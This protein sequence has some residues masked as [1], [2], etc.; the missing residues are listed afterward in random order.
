MQAVAQEIGGPRVGVRLSPVTPSNDVCDPHP[1]PL[2]D[3]LARQLG[4]L[5]LA[6]L[7]VIEGTTGG[8]R[9]HMQGEAPFDY[10]AMRTQ[11][12]DAGGTG[13]WMVNNGYDAALA[14]QSLS[15]GADL[16][17]FGRPFIANPDLPR[18]LRENRPLNTLDRATLYGGGAQGYTDY[19]ALA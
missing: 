9:D 19:P 1:Q 4:P 2:F 17:A 14:Q 8:A 12:R 10:G 3:H 18:R 16:I 15:Q 7:H 6:Y 11:Y 13:A 5:Q